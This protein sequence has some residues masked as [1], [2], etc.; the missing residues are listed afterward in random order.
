MF[1]FLYNSK[2]RYKFK[3]NCDML[4]SLFMYI[5]INPKNRLIGRAPLSFQADI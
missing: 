3:L 2:K 5:K 1:H 4:Y